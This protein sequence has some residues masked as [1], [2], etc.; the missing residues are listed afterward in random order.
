MELCIRLDLPNPNGD[1]T[2][3]TA[4]TDAHGE[5][6]IRVRLPFDEQQVSIIVRALDLNASS[7]LK[8]Q[9]SA[10]ESCILSAWGLVT[11]NPPAG[12]PLLITGEGLH[13]ERLRD[14]VRGK[15]YETLFSP[16]R[17][18]LAA[19]FVQLR[20]RGERVLHVHLEMWS[21]QVTLFQFPW[22]LLHGDDSFNGEIH[23]SRYIR[24]R[25]PV[26]AIIR[27]LRLRLLV[28]HSEPAGLQP[29]ALRD[30][31]YIRNGLRTAE[32]GS[33]FEIEPV[34]AASIR[35]LG[36]ALAHRPEYPTIVHFAGHGDFGWRC[37]HCR[38]LTTHI[39]RTRCEECDHP[40][41]PDTP[42]CGFLAFT[43]EE[44]ALPHWV[45][46][47]ELSDT[48]K[49]GKV[50]LVVLNACKS[51]LGRRGDDVFN[52]IAQRLMDTVPAVVATPF[53]LEN[54]G[55]HEFARCF[56]E[57]LG[58]GLPLVEALH[59]VRLRLRPMFPDEWFR[60]VLYLRS[61]QDD[62]GHILDLA[63]AGSAAE[64]K[65]DEP[66]VSNPLA[67]ELAAY[68]VD[69]RSQEGEFR[70]L[71]EAHRGRDERDKQ[72]PSRKRPLL[73]LLP[74][75]TDDYAAGYLLERLVYALNG[76]LR[77]YDD[78]YK[79]LEL[80]RTSEPKPLACTGA[81]DPKLLESKLIQSIRETQFGSRSVS[82][83]DFVFTEPMIFYAHL[84][85]AAMKAEGP[86]PFLRRFYEFWGGW[87]DQNQLL[88]ICA[89][90]S[91]LKSPCTAWERAIDLIRGHSRTNASFE[92]LLNELRPGTSAAIE[93]AI[94]STLK[95]VCKLDATQWAR[96]LKTLGILRHQRAHRDLQDRIEDLFSGRCTPLVADCLPFG[97]LCRKLDD[98]LL[99]CQSGNNP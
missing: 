35:R 72:N 29:L 66:A 27:A 1:L 6:R 32:L 77:R 42:P 51:A 43:H 15:L 84:E 3:E 49:L 47:G 88:L 63:A 37:E 36:D 53:P 9:F 95:P 31:V 79:S 22:E 5:Q 60:P 19:D 96:R 74:G 89:F 28:L 92:A 52:G 80:D 20:L 98:F 39:G 62:G 67:P 99:E 16:L 68:L 65:V 11:D 46:A 81:E 71:I 91:Y 75:W 50:Q 7:Y 40:F 82:I 23:I 76:E 64:T 44:S 70:R 69:C 85:L 86:A 26:A 33:A 78:N 94:L 73:L 57:G 90:V 2:L 14:L 54:Q 58:N 8:R 55:A 12:G 4:R 61:I 13:R 25:R 97:D 24:Y 18:E 59:Q 56:Y 41:P 21:D 83:R 30:Q 17:A 38:A 48:L 87:G 10:E 34:D 45:S 93:G